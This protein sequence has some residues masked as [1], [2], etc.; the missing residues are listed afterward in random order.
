M[1]KEIEELIKDEYPEAS[2]IFFHKDGEVYFTLPPRKYD[3][4]EV[5]DMENEDGSVKLEITDAHVEQD[6]PDDPYRRTLSVTAKAMLD[7][8]LRENRTMQ[9]IRLFEEFEKTEGGGRREG[10]RRPRADETKN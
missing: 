3:V 1:K 6:D 5:H 10:T 9:H 7:D 4:D 8:S 2:N